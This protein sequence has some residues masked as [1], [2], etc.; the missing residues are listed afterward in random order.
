M[1]LTMTL[2]RVNYV[3]RREG[4]GARRG[5]RQVERPKGQSQIGLLPLFAIGGW[6]VEMFQFAAHHKIAEIH[7]D[8]IRD[9]IIVIQHL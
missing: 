9:A 7:H 8:M 1:A 6:K 3:I 5:A 4:A 2:H